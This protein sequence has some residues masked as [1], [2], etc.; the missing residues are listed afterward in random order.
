MKLKSLFIH[1]FQ[2]TSPLTRFRIPTRM[3]VL[4]I[5]RRGIRN[6]LA[7]SAPRVAPRRSEAYK[8]PAVCSILFPFRWSF[9]ASGNS[10]PTKIAIIRVSIGNEMPADNVMSVT[11]S[12]AD[13]KI[14]INGS[15]RE[16]INIENSI[17]TMSFLV[18][19]LRFRFIMYAP[20]ARPSMKKAMITPMYW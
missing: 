6:A 3:Q 13:K 8:V 18:L 7:S 1:L 20:V 19:F 2:I 12:R 5:P 14:N 15:I 10:I 17:F 4:I 16:N 11:F 9:E